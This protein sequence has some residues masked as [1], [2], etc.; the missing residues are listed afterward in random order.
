I[1]YFAFGKLK[2]SRSYFLIINAVEKLF[3]VF[4]ILM[5]SLYGSVN[6]TVK[7]LEVIVIMTVF[8]LFPNKWLHSFSSSFIL[9]AAFFVYS[10]MDTG[11]NAD[12]STIVFGFTCILILFVLNS[13]NSYVVNYLRRSKYYE[14]IMLKKLINVDT[15]TGAYNRAKFNEDIKKLIL[16]SKTAGR[17]FSIAIFDI[18]NFK[19][20][21]DTF[22]HLVGDKILTGIVDIASKLKRPSDIL[23][24]WGGEEFVL[25]L[26]STNLDDAL[27]ITEKLRTAIACY[28]FGI[29]G[30]VTCSFGLTEFRNNDTHTTIFRRADKLLYDAK[31]S[32]KNIVI[33]D[34]M[35]F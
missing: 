4:Y 35:E 9:V 31:A 33:Y 1:S 20:I 17:V 14:T 18:D 12:N 13:V 7:C 26:P 3:T 25:L 27:K 10:L 34:D 22:G 28:D 23:S 24:R 6:F 21:N 32:G 29:K 2:N 15:L 30:R 19:R 5:L 11:N 8:F 16:K